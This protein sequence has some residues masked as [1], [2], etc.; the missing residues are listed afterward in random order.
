MQNE[1]QK[2]N[3]DVLLI[4][5]ASGTGK[6]SVSRALARLYGIDLVR[7][8]DFQIMLETLTTAQSLPAIHYWTTHPEWMEE[9]AQATA[10][11]L[12]DIGRAVSP[13][14]N[15]VIQDH[16]AEAIPMILEGDFI[17][18]ELCASWR[19]PRVQSVLIHEPERNQILQNFHVREG[20]LQPY[21]AD[22]SQYYD[23]WLVKS[24]VE[25]G[26]P[27][28]EARPWGTV[29]ERVIACLQ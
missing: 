29:V 15:A 20:K 1:N 18:P 22:V 11:H 13:G 17:L 27:V 5:G 26:I 10:N 24:C 21:R 6:T 7:V 4:G 9:G 14:L 8:D 3:W 28:V 16:L 12:I 19:D 23:N 2:R 25:L